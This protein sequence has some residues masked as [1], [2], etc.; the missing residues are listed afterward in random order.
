MYYRRRC[1]QYVSRHNQLLNKLL[2]I[3]EVGQF[4]AVMYEGKIRLMS[5]SKHRTTSARKYNCV[6]R[7]NRYKRK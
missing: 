7:L 2:S 5:E 1:S 4:T 6:L 3:Q